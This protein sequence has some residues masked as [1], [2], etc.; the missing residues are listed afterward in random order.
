[1]TTSK[2][3]SALRHT[4]PMAPHTAA[5]R[6]Q[7]AER[8]GGVDTPETWAPHCRASAVRSEPV[9]QPTRVA[10]GACALG[11]ARDSPAGPTLP[12]PGPRPPLVDL[13]SARL[14][15]PRRRCLNPLRPVGAGQPGSQSLHPVRAVPACSRL[16]PR[17]ENQRD[18]CSASPSPTETHVSA[19]ARPRT[20]MNLGLS[21]GALDPRKQGEKLLGT[22]VCSV[23]LPAFPSRSPVS[24]RETRVSRIWKYLITEICVMSHRNL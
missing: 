7:R 23:R 5:G 20:F 3:G 16:C 19:S 11:P 8:P 2:R 9:L 15:G 22:A 21:S 13:S 17:S 1:M 24:N 4:N 18:T 10:D 14:R 6:G 12:R